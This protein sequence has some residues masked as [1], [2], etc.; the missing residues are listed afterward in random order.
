VAINLINASKFTDKTTG[1]IAMGI[2]LNEKTD[3]AL[4]SGCIDQIKRDLV[5]NNEACEAL[6]LSTLGNIGSADLA[7]ELSPAVIH[8]ALSDDR[9]TTVGVRKKACL[10]LLSFLRRE[11]SIYDPNGWLTQF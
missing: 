2:M 7:K 5:S 8:K 1:Y 4:F 11:K 10:C 9:Q 3:F 6:A